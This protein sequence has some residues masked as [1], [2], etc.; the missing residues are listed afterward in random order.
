MKT[1][2]PKPKQREPSA[3]R[4]RR[5][6]DDPRFLVLL[7]AATTAIYTGAF[8]KPETHD[9]EDDEHW[10]A[11]WLAF[12]VFICAE[13]VYKTLVQEEDEIEEFNAAIGN[14]NDGEKQ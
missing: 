4:N 8:D 5:M 13:A 9:T 12:R 10:T 3:D 6:K 14:N 1:A 7:A 11:E 2:N